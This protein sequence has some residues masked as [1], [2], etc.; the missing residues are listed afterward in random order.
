VAGIEPL[1]GVEQKREE[2]LSLKLCGK[3]EQSP[4]TYKDNVARSVGA[5]EK[6]SSYH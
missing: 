3:R 4:E 5:G 2:K 1:K 6:P